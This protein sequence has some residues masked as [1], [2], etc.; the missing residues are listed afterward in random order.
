M[1]DG[2]LLL[3]GEFPLRLLRDR[4]IEAMRSELTAAARAY[5]SNTA[6]DLS[7][8]ESRLRSVIKDGLQCPHGVAYVCDRGRDKLWLRLVYI[9]QVI[10]V[11]T[12]RDWD[13]GFDWPRWDAITTAVPEMQRARTEVDIG[14]GCP[15]RFLRAEQRLDM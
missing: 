2:N 12:Q 5:V 14:E 4:D 7:E 6:S 1:I 15:C 11:A 10:P 9:N 13:R 3:I 8:V